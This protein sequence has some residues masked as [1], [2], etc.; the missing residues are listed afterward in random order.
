MKI[1]SDLLNAKGSG[2]S[3]IPNIDLKSNHCPNLDKFY[4][5]INITIDSHQ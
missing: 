2:L 1:Y 5:W 3:S 4:L